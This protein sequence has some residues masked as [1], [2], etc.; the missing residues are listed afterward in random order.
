MVIKHLQCTCICTCIVSNYL[1]PCIITIRSCKHTKCNEENNLHTLP[2]DTTASGR[3][4]S[5]AAMLPVTICSA[6]NVLQYEDK[7]FSMLTEPSI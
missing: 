4:I 3:D 1:F 2:G 6:K 5:N 7:K